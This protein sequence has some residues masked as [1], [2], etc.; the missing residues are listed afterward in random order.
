MAIQYYQV[1]GVLPNLQSTQLIDATRIKPSSFIA[2]FKDSS[3]KQSVLVDTTF[4]N[5]PRHLIPWTPS[6]N[7]SLGDLAKGFFEYYWSVFDPNGQVV[8]IAAGAPFARRLPSG[9][10]VM[11]RPVINGGSRTNSANG[12]PPL[13][14]ELRSREPFNE[15]E[16]WVTQ[17]LVVQDPFILGLYPSR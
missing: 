8:S 11:P 7:L 12:H 15:P 10:G 14:P 1:A 17:A 9:K 16:D 3:G 5:L 6:E 2:K 13:L 4:V